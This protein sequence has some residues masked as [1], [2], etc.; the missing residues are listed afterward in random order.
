MTNN[1]INKKHIFLIIALISIISLLGIIS[2]SSQ[3]KEPEALPVPA[4]LQVEKRILTWDPV[5]NSSGYT[6]RINGT[7]YTADECSFDLRALTAEGGAYAIDISALGNSETHKDSLWTRISLSFEA[8]EEH[9]IDGAGFEY[10]LLPDKSGYEFSPGKADVGGFVTIPDFYGDYPIKSIAEN[11]FGLWMNAS[12]NNS[13]N[14]FT[15]NLCNKVTT[16]IKL[17]AYL[18]TIG[19]KAFAFMVRLEEIV[20]P[21]TVTEINDEAFMGCSHMTRVV[22]PEGLKTIPSKCFMDTALSEIILPNGL[23]EIRQSAFECTYRSRIYKKNEFGEMVL[24]AEEHI[25]SDVSSVIIPDSVSIIK[26][27]AFRGRDNLENIT[28]EDPCNIE[29]MQKNVFKDTLWYDSQPQGFIFFGSLLYEYKGNIP[30]DHADTVLTLPSHV[31]KVAD[32]ALEKKIYLQKVTVP[33]S[34][35]S[36][37]SDM[38][39][40]CASLSEVILSDGL[41]TISSGAFANTE[42]LK[43]IVI[44][45]SVTYIA[46]G[47][48]ENSKIEKITIPSGTAIESSTFSFCSELK[49]VVLPEGLVI[50]KNSGFNKCSS[51]TE[52]NL[53]EKIEII[54]NLAFNECSSL[55]EIVLPNSLKELH[56]NSFTDCSALKKVILPK[57]IE[58][59][60]KMAFGEA[61]ES[62]H[63]YFA[64]S[65]SDFDALLLKNEVTQKQ[66]FSG[67]TVYF[68][69]ETAP[70]AEGN[71]WHYVDGEP[72]PWN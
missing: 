14:I 65:S 21:N 58:V 35:K 11:A 4:N 43:T 49:E 7:E 57:G 42:N 25:Y 52:I 22:L 69:S 16:G 61:D 47:A 13:P 9:G 23:E 28:I 48:F 70:T 54:E 40:G 29:L 1:V 36:I 30:K 26:E 45:S 6:V 56:Q 71:F 50:I 31:K 24:V 44:P 60:K 37:S 68:Y 17:P 10:T 53:P 32:S 38:F 72:T 27:N 51:L 64:G 5:V 33:S 66:V 39:N 67:A 41:E 12:I 63:I 59:I 8:A 18:E 15:E 2:C 19:A 20:I 55:E 62:M 3:K 34:I 46:S